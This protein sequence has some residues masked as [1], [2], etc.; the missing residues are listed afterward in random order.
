MT[1]YTITATRD[2]GTTITDRV[3]APTPAEARKNFKDAHH[4]EG[5]VTITGV[6]VYREN[7]SASKDQERAA[8]EQIRAIVATLGPNSYVA[9]AL[10]GCLE[11]AEENIAYDFADSYKGRFEVAQA[12]LEDAK[13]ALVERTVEREK[14]LA[15]VDA[16]EKERDRLASCLLTPEDLLDIKVTVEKSAAEWERDATEAA[17]RIVEY[18]D[19][20]AAKAFTDAVKAHREAQAVAKSFRDLAARVAAA[21]ARYLGEVAGT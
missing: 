18:A 5:M 7:V 21:R 19:T 11:V 15:R 1:T 4:S 14:A 6:E 8:L 3:S 13:K 16:L 10:D 20:P 9:T 17:G 12:D 2:N